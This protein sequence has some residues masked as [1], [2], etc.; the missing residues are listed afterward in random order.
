MQHG[1]L[2]GVILSMQ[3]M[4]PSVVSAQLIDGRLRMATDASSTNLFMAN[5]AAVMPNRT[6]IS[7]VRLTE[8]R[9]YSYTAGNGQNTDDRESEIAEVDHAFGVLVPLGGGAAFGVTGQFLGTDMESSSESRSEAVDE[10]F[11]R[12]MGSIRAIVDLTPV[13]RF[14]FEYRMT[15]VRA[16]VRGSFNVSAQDSTRYLG[17]VAGYALG[18]FYEANN[19]GLGVS[20]APAMRGKAE[21]EGEEKVITEPGALAIDAYFKQGAYVYG[22]AAERRNYQRDERA[23]AATS[24]NDQRTMSLNGL[25]FEQFYM[26]TDLVMVG[27]DYQVKQDIWLRGSMGRQWGVFLFDEEEVPGGNEDLESAVS[28]Y[29]A[30][31]ALA[32]VKADFRAEIAVGQT[33]RS[34]DE[35]FDTEGWFG[36]RQNSDYK[37]TAR[38]IAMS[39]SFVQ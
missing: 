25:D 31:V 38:T 17:R 21:V 2:W 36:A 27:M 8:D 23:E 30:R 33:W 9:E 4:L 26:P 14:G 20:T 34:A 15:E 6:W 11:R 24:P 32:F 1:W 39:F 35:I 19:M 5:P 12:R 18:L 3:I 29:V 16:Q 28:S 10:N 37:G 13:L 22:I 7:Y